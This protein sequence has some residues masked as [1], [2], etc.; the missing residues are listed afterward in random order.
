MHIFSEI[1]LEWLFLMFIVSQHTQSVRA[2][3]L[4]VLLQRP[5]TQWHVTDTYWK[6]QSGLIRMPDHV[7]NNP[8][9]FYRVVYVY[10]LTSALLCFL[11]YRLQYKLAD[12][13]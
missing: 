6:H 1:I 12:E 11:A 7:K 10:M 4:S 3:S 5:K 13:K 9:I 8:D 2:S